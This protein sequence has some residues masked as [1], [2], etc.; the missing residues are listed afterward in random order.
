MNGWVGVY[1]L[2]KSVSAGHRVSS[3][4]IDMLSLGK[5]HNGV[6]HIV[7]VITEGLDGN[8]TRAIGVLHDHVDVG[9]SETCFVE[10]LSVVFLGL[11]LV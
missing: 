1:Y 11:S 4:W 3:G 5:G 8:V 6:D 2:L 7:I 10:W 9:G